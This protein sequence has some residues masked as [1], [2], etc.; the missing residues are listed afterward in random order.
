MTLLA[1]A[2]AFSSVRIFIEMKFDFQ[3]D[4]GDLKKMNIIDKKCNDDITN[5]QDREQQANILLRYLTEKNEMKRYDEFIEYV[6]AKNKALANN[7]NDAIAYKKKRFGLTSAKREH[8]RFQKPI[9]EGNTGK[10]GKHLALCVK[11]K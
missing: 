11:I 6:M 1:Y 7:I 2:E 8:K 3:N 9:G 4:V 5:A 10:E